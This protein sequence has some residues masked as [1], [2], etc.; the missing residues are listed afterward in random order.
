MDFEEKTVLTGQ[1]SLFT[2]KRP[3][4]ILKHV[5]YIPAVGEEVEG[6]FVINISYFIS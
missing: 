5:S 6:V 2:W 4:A 1:K 3:A